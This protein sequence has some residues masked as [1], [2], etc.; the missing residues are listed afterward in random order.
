MRACQADADGRRWYVGDRVWP[1]GTGVMAEATELRISALND[2]RATA[3]VEHVALG[4]RF[5][6][7]LLR[8]VLSRHATRD[9]WPIAAG[10]YPFGGGA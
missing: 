1:E 3:A 7:P 10:D 4:Y 2:D 9:E 8:L 5:T 6:V